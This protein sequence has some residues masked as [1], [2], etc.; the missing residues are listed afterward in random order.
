M[1]WK[2][3]IQKPWKIRIQKLN[4]ETKLRNPHSESRKHLCRDLPVL[5]CKSK[6]WD[7]KG[8]P[9]L[10]WSVVC[11]VVSWV[12]NGVRVQSNNSCNVKNCHCSSSKNNLKHFQGVKKGY[13]RFVMFC[14]KQNNFAMNKF[15]SKTSWTHFLALRQS[16]LKADVTQGQNEH[17]PEDCTLIL[18]AFLTQPHTVC[19]WN[20]LRPVSDWVSIAGHQ[21]AI[22]VCEGFQNNSQNF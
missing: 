15:R 4:S 9:F 17:N 19:V 3:C 8:W 5:S 18:K 2:K 10:C 14:S 16:C 13:F 22:W 20:H 11:P 21:L 1:S 12:F 6:G 7:K